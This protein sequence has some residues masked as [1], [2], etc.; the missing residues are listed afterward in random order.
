M[1]L[2]VEFFEKQGVEFDPIERAILG[3]VCAALPGRTAEECARR[4]RKAFLVRLAS[5]IAGASIAAPDLILVVA[6]ILS[7]G[8]SYVLL[9]C[10]FQIVSRKAAAIDEKNKFES[11][12]RTAKRFQYSLDAIGKRS[13]SERIFAFLK[14]CLMAVLAAVERLR[15]ALGRI[16]HI[17][18]ATRLLSSPASSR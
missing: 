17:A 3:F 15:S 4:K 16:S 13:T 18:L 8:F 12:E 6:F 11:H 2:S 1:N 9:S 14:F 10:A 5:L 7:A